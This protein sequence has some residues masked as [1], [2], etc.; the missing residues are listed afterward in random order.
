MARL[1]WGEKDCKRSDLLKLLE[2]FEYGLK[3]SEVADILR[4]DRRTVNNYLRELEAEMRV[5]KEG[6]LWFADEQD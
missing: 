4:W 1:F 5:Y 2:R 3:E 6:R